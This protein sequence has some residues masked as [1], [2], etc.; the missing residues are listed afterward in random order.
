MRNLDTDSLGWWK[1]DMWNKTETIRYQWRWSHWRVSTTMEIDP[2]IQHSYH[3]FKGLLC[4]SFYLCF[5][6]HHRKEIRTILWMNWTF[7]RKWVSIQTWCAWW[8][9]VIYKVSI[10]LP[11]LFIQKVLFLEDFYRTE[12]HDVTLKESDMLLCIYFSSVTFWVIFFF[13]VVIVEFVI[14]IIKLCNSRYVVLFSSRNYVRCHGILR[15]RRFA[16]LLTE[17]EAM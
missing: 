9:L 15:K 7:W 1:R 2:L 12:H 4:K 16:V 13:G 8:A 11:S 17:N 14:A 6:S 3:N 5:Q 10:F